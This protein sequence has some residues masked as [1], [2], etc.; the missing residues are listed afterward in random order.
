MS[1]P[2]LWS[3]YERRRRRKKT[4]SIFGDL[5]LWQLFT[6]LPRGEYSSI[7]MFPPYLSLHLKHSSHFQYSKTETLFREIPVYFCWMMK[8]W[9]WQE[10]VWLR[11]TVS[12][13][14]IF[15]QHPVHVRASLCG[16]LIKAQQWVLIKGIGLLWLIPCVTGNVLNSMNHRAPNTQAWLCTPTHTHTLFSSK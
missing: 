3:A 6:P 12:K 4:S 1:W 8:I 15:Q 5:P 14:V 9:G 2:E 16:S 10:G 11:E 13:S 7:R